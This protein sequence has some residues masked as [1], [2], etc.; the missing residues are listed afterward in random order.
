MLPPG[1]CRAAE[2]LLPT[3]QDPRC[4]S[5]DIQTGPTS[6]KRLRFLDAKF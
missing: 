6:L 3:A 1:G 5:Q 2:A 4:E